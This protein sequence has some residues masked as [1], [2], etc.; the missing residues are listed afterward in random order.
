[1]TKW[2]KK[3]RWP[4]LFSHVSNTPVHMAMPSCTVKFNL[5]RLMQN[6]GF[7]LQ[8]RWDIS[9]TRVKEEHGSL[10]SS[11]ISGIGWAIIYHCLQQA[12]LEIADY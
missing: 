3:I 9:L 12:T 2:E 8:V 10:F 11:Y 5:E 4:L 6:L 1:M 7:S